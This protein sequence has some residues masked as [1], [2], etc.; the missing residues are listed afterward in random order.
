[1]LFVSLRAGGLTVSTNLRCGGK[2][3]TASGRQPVMSTFPVQHPRPCHSD[4]PP[5]DVTDWRRCRLIEA[6]FP[7]ALAAA[8]ART[9]SVDVHALLQLVDRGCPPELAARIL[10]PLGASA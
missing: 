4:G 6:G 9:P 8:L 10:S 1:M 2:T 7:V 5:A 3:G